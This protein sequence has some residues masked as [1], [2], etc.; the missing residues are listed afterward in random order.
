MES[1]AAWPVHNQ[2]EYSSH[3]VGADWGSAVN[4]SLDLCVLFPVGMN[5][6]FW[7]CD[8]LSSVWLHRHGYGR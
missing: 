2:F 1:L 4:I 3:E 8:F 5:D 6:P 7:L